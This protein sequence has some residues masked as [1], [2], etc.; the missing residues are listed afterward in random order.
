MG[1]DTQVEELRSVDPATLEELG[2]VPISPPEEVSEAVAEARVAAARWA[3]SSFA[4]RRDLLGTVAQ[5]VLAR[6]DVLTA[7]VTAET[8]KPLVESYTAEL[9][10]S[11]DN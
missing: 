9:F 10:V 11:L 7:T 4:E 1:R 6:A 3:N 5:E 2:G 8:G